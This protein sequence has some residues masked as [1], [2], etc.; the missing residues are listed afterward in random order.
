DA[1]KTGID[2]N[3]SD[4]E[5]IDLIVKLRLASA[6]LIVAPTHTIDD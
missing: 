3:V 4:V 5:L 2:A 1:L 6:A